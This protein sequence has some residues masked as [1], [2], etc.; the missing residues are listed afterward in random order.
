MLS[1]EREMSFFDTDDNNTYDSG[2]GNET[3]SETKDTDFF[4][5]S[6]YEDSDYNDTRSYS[7]L[8]TYSKIDD[9]SS[10]YSNEYDLNT[11]FSLPESKA[12][13]VV[14]AK[15]EMSKVQMKLPTKQ[16]NIEFKIPVIPQY[17]STTSKQYQSPKKI[18]NHR[19]SQPHENALT[20]YMTDIQSKLKHSEENIK[21]IHSKNIEIKQNITEGIDSL[22]SKD[23]FLS[24]RSNSETCV[25]SDISNYIGSI[26]KLR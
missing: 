3:I 11:N 16:L 9:L 5:I 7:Q 8:E 26:S 22:Q 17:T 4:Q 12:F 23:I 13:P 15:E 6:N 18:T 14:E 20:D 24:S 2:M 10:Q 19:D 25:L 1:I 21:L